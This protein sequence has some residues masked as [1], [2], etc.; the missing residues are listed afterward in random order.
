MGTLGHKKSGIVA[1]LTSAST[2]E[3]HM[4]YMSPANKEN[5]FSVIAVFTKQRIP[6]SQKI[7]K[8]N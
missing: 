4:I 2:V 8:R 5:A 3:K 6:Y 1:S 7:K